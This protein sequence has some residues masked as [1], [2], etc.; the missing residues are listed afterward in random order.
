[1]KKF[2]YNEGGKT[3]N[4]VA[5]RGGACPIPGNTQGQVRLGS[6]QPNLVENVAAGLE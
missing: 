1:M 6:E 4:Q 2:F 5:Q 3:P